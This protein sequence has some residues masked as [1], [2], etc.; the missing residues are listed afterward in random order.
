MVK[1]KT[2]KEY[3]QDIDDLHILIYDYEDEI[4]DL[5]DEITAGIKKINELKESNKSLMNEIEMLKERIPHHY[6]KIEDVK[7]FDELESGYY[8]ITENDISKIYEIKEKE[9]LCGV[10]YF[11]SSNGDKI[12]RD[13]F[14]DLVIKQFFYVE[15]GILK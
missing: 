14:K 10:K 6:F 2:N 11:K 12:T 8:Y 13:N 15:G 4:R 1:K 3:K 9:S 5:K 7:T